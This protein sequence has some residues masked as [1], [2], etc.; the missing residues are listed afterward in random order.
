MNNQSIMHPKHLNPL[1]TSGSGPLALLQVLE[2]GNSEEKW[3]SIPK[4]QVFIH[5]LSQHV[6]TRTIVAKAVLRLI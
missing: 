6:L 5:H 1:G 2:Q 4:T 3:R